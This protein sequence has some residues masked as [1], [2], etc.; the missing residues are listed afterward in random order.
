MLT[1]INYERMF[2]DLV[3][4]SV[5]KT[6]VE[7]TSTDS[8]SIYVLYNMKSN[9]DGTDISVELKVLLQLHSCLKALR[10][11]TSK[12]IYIKGFTKWLIIENRA[13]IVHVTRAG[14]GKFK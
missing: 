7:N 9:Q 12:H 6:S 14:L 5:L 11:F 2:K 3:R 8:I 4:A 10:N 1:D 13:K